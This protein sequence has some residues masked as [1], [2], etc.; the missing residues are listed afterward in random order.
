MLSHWV[1]T[2]VLGLRQAAHRLIGD[3]IEVRGKMRHGEEACRSL[4]SGELV[5][6]SNNR[7]TRDVCM[8]LISHPSIH[9][10]LSKLTCPYQSSG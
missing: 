6:R 1:Q 2:S 10:R 9:L 8:I 3:M 5:D 7:R 4:P